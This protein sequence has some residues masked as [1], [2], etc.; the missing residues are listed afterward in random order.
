MKIK[1][2]TSQHRNDF[3]A[4]MACEHCGHIHKLTS[5]YNDHYYHAAVIPAM[6]CQKCGLN[7]AGEKRVAEVSE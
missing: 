7:R 3:S 2:I 4:D 6:H 1:K 5:G